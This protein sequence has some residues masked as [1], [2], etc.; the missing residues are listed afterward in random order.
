MTMYSEQ[1]LTENDPDKSHTMIADLFF[2]FSRSTP[3]LILYSL[4]RT[5]RTLPEISKSLKMT[6]KAVLP[7]LMELRIKDVLVSFSKSQKTYYR[8]ADNRIL[9]ALDLILKVSQKKVKQADTRSPGSTVSGISR[10]DQD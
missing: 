9:Q 4:R 10:K 2:L 7:E 6:Q 1:K 5:A 3:L 8:L